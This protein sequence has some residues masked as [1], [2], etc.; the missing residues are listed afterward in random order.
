MDSS[1]CISS[2]E[3]GM[4]AGPQAVSD[5]TIYITQRS[6]IV[7]SEVETLE[8]EVMTEMPTEVVT[9]A[10]TQVPVT[11]ETTVLPATTAATPGFT[12][13]CALA[14]VFAALCLF[15]RRIN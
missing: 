4:M 1:A 10:V 14:A 8:T 7:K 11:A 6:T 3:D 2:G 15:V 5:F 13:F 12:M 9:A